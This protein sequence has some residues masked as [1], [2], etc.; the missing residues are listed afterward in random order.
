MCKCK[1]S[2]DFLM[3]FFSSKFQKSKLFFNKDLK[4][5]FFRGKKTC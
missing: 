1:Y 2:I 4:K 5:V 3:N